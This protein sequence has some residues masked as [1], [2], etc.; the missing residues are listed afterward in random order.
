MFEKTKKGLLQVGLYFAFL[1]EVL[2]A[3]IRRPYRIKLWLS[4]IETLG[5]KSIPI[6]VLSG[7]AIGM[8]FALQMV[9]LLQPFQGEMGVG[10]AVAIAMSREFAPIITV[11]MLIAK[12]GSAMAAELGSMRVTEQIDALESMSVNPIQYLVVPRLLAAVVTF[13][14]LT[15]LANIVG[16][17][18][19]YIIS[20]YLYQIDSATYLD[21]M[22]T[23]LMPS[24]VITGLIKASFMGAI[25]AT[26]CCFYGLNSKEG[27]K[28][29]GDGAT[30]GVVVSSVA[31]LIADYFLATIIMNILGA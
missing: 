24:D 1:G 25:V 3:A 13:P 22:F 21:Y 4:E 23:I 27:A 11:L 8:I 6:I 28:G 18:G 10:A 5:I 7:S 2:S 9:S 15:I 26:V 12:N 16:V 19:S 31:I 20:I 30:K 14:V 17:L 29:V